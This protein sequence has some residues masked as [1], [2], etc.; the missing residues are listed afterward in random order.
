MSLRA[1]WVLRFAAFRNVFFWKPPWCWPQTC[2]PRVTLDINEAFIVPRTSKNLLSF[3]SH[4]LSNSCRGL[5]LVSNP[6]LT[7]TAVLFFNLLAVNSL[8]GEWVATMWLAGQI[9]TVTRCSSENGFQLLLTLKTLAY[10]QST[11]LK[12][13]SSCPARCHPLVLFPFPSPVM[14]LLDP[15]CSVPEKWFSPHMWPL[16]TCHQAG[17]IPYQ[18]WHAQLGFLCLRV[19]CYADLHVTHCVWVEQVWLQRACCRRQGPEWPREY[20]RHLHGRGAPVWSVASAA[21]THTSL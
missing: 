16:P 7:L 15:Y 8:N 21:Q 6:T 4:R 13:T 19:T 5:R 2:Y 9:F 14:P 18:A 1:S 12:I 17:N 3:A 10:L 20:P 11:I